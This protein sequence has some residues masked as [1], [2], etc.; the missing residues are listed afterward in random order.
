MVRAQLTSETPLTQVY[1]K[2]HHLS[3][4]REEPLRTTAFDKKA[5][6]LARIT[7]RL[8]RDFARNGMKFSPE[9]LLTLNARAERVNEFARNM[10]VSRA[11]QI[12]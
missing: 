9:R 5:M 7:H 6:Q 3:K 2:T 8:Y 11:S 12:H 1:I 4:P 10:I